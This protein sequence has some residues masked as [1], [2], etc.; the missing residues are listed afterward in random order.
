[1][2]CCANCGKGEDESFH[3]KECTACKMVKYCNRDCQVA[4]RSQHKKTCKK[5][6][7]E[8]HD[9][10][11]FKQPP[12]SDDCPICM[13]P[14]PAIGSGWRYKSCCG[15]DICSVCIHA[16]Q[17][18]DG[19]VG[20]CPFC[21]TLTTPTPE[22][23]IEQRKKRVDERYQSNVGLGC[24]YFHGQYGLPQNYGKALEL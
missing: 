2:L 21:R 11:L 18:R 9:E 22:V 4:H 12:P 1:M 17:I 6:A 23:S 10:K 16:M 19:G 24:D 14:L 13:L 7:A 5:R 8:L 3:L 15:K 20:L